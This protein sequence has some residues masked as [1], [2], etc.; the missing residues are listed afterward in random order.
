MKEP[1][2]I[3]DRIKDLKKIKKEFDEEPITNRQEIKIL[4]DRIKTLE[5]VL[6]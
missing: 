5:W 3:S 2:Q 1:K 6:N 4:N